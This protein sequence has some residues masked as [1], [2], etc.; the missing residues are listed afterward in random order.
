MSARPS[1][2]TILVFARAPVVGGVKTRLATR[3]GPAGAADAHRACILDA[4]RLVASLPGC[5][6]RLL[7][8]GDAREWGKAGLAPGPGWQIEPQR[9]RELGERLEHAFAES[10]R[11]GARKVLAIGTDTP[12]MGVQR[13]RTSMAWLD[14]D[15]V[16]VG[17]SFDGGYY[18]VAANRMVP[19]IFRGI[20]WGT[21]TVLNATRMALGRAAA[22]YRQLPWDFDLDRPTDLDRARTLLRERSHRAPN[23][24][25]FLRALPVA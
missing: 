12:W 17:P 5:T 3:L 2:A 21:S 23:L 9:G 6:R 11:R 10:F 24:A 4:I 20:P 14:A 19:E 13:L 1:C 18:L 15:E 16:V 8:T 7:I 25:A 22:P